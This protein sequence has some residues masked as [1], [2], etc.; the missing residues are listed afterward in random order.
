[1]IVRAL[2]EDSKNIAWSSH[3]RERFR[4]REINN[5]MAM[6]VLR[7]GGISGEIVTGK[8]AGEWKAKLTFPV[9]GRREVGVVMILIRET[10]ILVKTVEW[11]D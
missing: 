6:M 9:P 2:A 1:M 8:M 11:E 4:G 7:C 5:R 3:A 10:R